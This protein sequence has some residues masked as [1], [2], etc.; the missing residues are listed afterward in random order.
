MPRSLYRLTAATVSKAKKPGTYADG[1]GL[2]LQVTKAGVKSWL[3]KYE[4]AG[5]RREMGLGPVRDVTLAEAREKAAEMRRLR[6]AGVDPMAQRDE[7]RRAREAAAAAAMTF[8][9]AAAACIVDKTPGWANAKH[10]AQWT[11][12][13]E[14]YVYPTIGDMSVDQ[15]E[16]PH[17]L[18][19]LRPIWTTIPETASRVRGRVETVL[20]WA[21]VS[22]LRRGENPARW[23]GH[24]D[25]ILPPRSKV[26]AVVHHAA[27]PY[28][29]VPAFMAEL[30]QVQATAARAMEFLILNANR[31]SEALYALDPEFALS[32]VDEAIWT[33]PATRMKAKVEHVIPLAAQAVELVERMRVERP[34][35]PYVFPGPDGM[36]LS[37]MSLLMLLRR[38]G[39]TDIT[40]H[41]FRSA[42]KDWAAEQTAFPNEVSE[43]ALAH[44]IKDKAEAAYRRGSILQKRRRLMQAWADYCLSPALPAASVTPLRRA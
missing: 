30:R 16:T 14:T 3:F 4:A 9:Q 37:N 10:A 12:T 22:Q 33:I 36:P 31:T 21:K 15:V 29:Q 44:R 32:P 17:I 35:G 7:Q 39:R 24:L 5:K 23:K 38:M 1:G 34:R 27:L 25:Q 18:A 43:M 13:L 41:G 2:Y 20:D 8:R 11:A 19:V 26:A 40:S 6:L 42:F 28:V